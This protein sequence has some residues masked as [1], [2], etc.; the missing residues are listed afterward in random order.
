LYSFGFSVFLSLF[1][2]INGSS[3]FCSSPHCYLF[4]EATL[5]RVKLGEAMYAKGDQSVAVKLWQNIIAED[6]EHFEAL[7]AYGM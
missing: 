1:L 7:F 3:V 5:L 6:D 2:F 4:S